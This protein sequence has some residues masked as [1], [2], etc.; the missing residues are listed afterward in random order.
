MFCLAWE[1]E[2]SKG[3]NNVV[4]ER[5]YLHHF[6]SRLQ[7]LSDFRRSLP[8]LNAVSA[9]ARIPA[10][11][12]GGCATG[13]TSIF[14]RSSV[15]CRS[16]VAVFTGSA[17]AARSRRHLAVKLAVAVSAVVAMLI[18]R[19]ILLALA[20]VILAAVCSWRRHVV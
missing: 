16:R 5:T 19:H 7:V 20:E 12:G 17:S 9:T 2:V 11:R 14:G 10:H 1:D 3:C 15:L 6:D 13:R 8:A 4:M 18:L